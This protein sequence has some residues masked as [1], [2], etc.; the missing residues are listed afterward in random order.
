MPGGSPR[1]VRRSR[2]SLVSRPSSPMGAADA[3]GD[4]LRSRRRGGGPAVASPGRRR[5][6]SGV[7]DPDYAQRL[8]EIRRQPPDETVRRQLSGILYAYRELIPAAPA[9]GAA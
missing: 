9:D 4:S 1:L 2:L 5:R 3:A 8:G 7:E 6:D